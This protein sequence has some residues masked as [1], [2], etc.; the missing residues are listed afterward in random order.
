[1]KST[2]R[3]TILA[4][5][6]AL[7]LA[8]SAPAVF[9]GST[10]KINGRVTGVDGSPLPGAS[11]VIEGRQ[12]GTVTD[13]EGFYVIVAVD[14]G[15][16]A[17][18]AS[19]VGYT[20]VTKK[21]V[22]VTI[23]YTTPVNF[24]LKEEAI[25]AAEIVVT[26]ERP[27]VELDKT[28][29]RYVLSPAD[30]DEAP[31][32]KSTA[33]L[34]GLQP[35]VDMGGT[36]SIRGSDV[37]WGEQKFAD[38]ATWSYA[39][40]DVKVLIDGV[41]V[42][43]NDGDQAN[44]FTGVNK[45]A[46]QQISIETGV[47]PA[48]YGDAQGGTINIVTQD[49]AKEYRGWI[50][51]NY[52]PVG[53]K[54]W[55]ANLY[56]A[57]IHRDRMRWDDPEWLAETDPVT[58]RVIH[59]RDNYD[60]VSGWLVEGS[61]SGPIGPKVSFLGSIKRQAF[62]APFPQPSERG[63]YNDR[64]R[65]MNADDFIQ[66]SGS[67]TLKPTPSTKVK[68][69]VVL[70]RWTGFQNELNEWGFFKNGYNR[71]LL[72]N[73]RNVFMPKNFSTMGRQ[74]RREDLEYVTFTHT[75]TPKT[76]YE[77]RFGRSRT[78]Q[79]TMDTVGATI[80]G[81]KDADGWFNTYK[82]IKM[83]MLS[84]RTRYSFKVDLSSQITKGNFVKTGFEIVRWSAWSQ[85]W[86][87]LRRADNWWT[88]YAGGDTPWVP[89]TPAKP[90]RGAIYVQDKMEFE[91]LI[92]NAGVRLDFNK[93]THRE[94]KTSAFHWAPMW[95]MYNNRHF[96]Y[97]QGSAP[98]GLRVSD[99]FIATPP[100]Q[101]AISPRLGV[102]HPI[103]DRAKLHFSLGRFVQWLEVRDQYSKSWRDYGRIGPDGD[104]TW[105]DLN[106]DGV[107]QAS[108]NMSNMEPLYF[109][110][111]GEPWVNPEETL[112]FEVGMD[113]NFVADYNAS[114][115][116]FY[117]NETNQIVRGATT[118]N[119]AKRGRRNT[120][121]SMNGRIA[122]GKGLEL[123]VGK[124]L[125]NYFSFRVAWTGMWGARGGTGISNHGAHIIADS[126]FVVSPNFWYDFTYGADGSAT[127]VPLTAQE[128][129]EFGGENNRYIQGLRD[130]ATE[131]LYLYFGGYDDATLNNL[132]INVRYNSY[133]G[134]WYGPFG[135]RGEPVVGGV[136]GQASVQFVLNTPSNVNF[137]G[138]FLSWLVS[139]LSATTLWTMRSGANVNWQPPEGGGAK[140]T[141]GPIES[142]TDLSVEKVFNAKGRLK[143]ALFVEIRNVFNDK[144]D[145]NP[146][147][148]R[149]TTG[150][151]YMLWGLDMAR[152]D[153]PDFLNY[154]DFGDRGYFG[155]PRQT[156][157]GL[158]L[159]F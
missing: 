104:P 2:R 45:S 81:R 129:V 107:R 10:G 85:Y 68:V 148:S 158:R 159:T 78:L 37:T 3:L 65:F 4:G 96:G 35:G 12:Q 40:T 147:S 32:V 75:L 153:N 145:I 146:I 46:V 42:P 25:E 124:R 17:L 100:T 143:P 76:F 116:M 113:W 27:P 15:A 122:Y 86:A 92:V 127:P 82:E 112:T 90:I 48:E 9:A 16:Y 138:R 20:S 95:R 79:D 126:N 137:G 156:N 22:N 50:E 105:Q 39:G 41:P 111:G 151:D 91:G 125:S 144:I 134:R 123:A 21:D 118:W 43:G 67:V 99:D 58:G 63:F 130:A 59:V 115:T 52:E 72:A 84:D 6:L 36:F 93:H 74:L 33:E 142:A 56:D 49:G 28:S 132:G 70:Q 18:T 31:L 106:S 101:F 109:G 51:G 87:G 149:G 110:P 38:N 60:E 24:T 150:T 73:G 13:T 44:I 30:I 61:L 8:L 57:P 141:K 139:D 34:I 108:E 98:A 77:V 135:I 157:M 133:G 155:T 14:P 103:T 102:S 62:A 11:L 1:M 29:T 5:M 80:D 128:K 121:G 119:G 71:G 131:N 19:L 53:Q 7:V 140:I 23:D 66:G 117:R 120:Q 26:A 136:I 83:W 94:L 154:G 97:G 89:G 47:T 88:M 152:P 64:G 54:H 114:L 55:G 69:G